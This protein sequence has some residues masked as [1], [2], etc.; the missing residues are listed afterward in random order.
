M[1]L[2]EEA[3]LTKQFG[4][5]VCLRAD[6]WGVGLSMALLMGCTSAE[7]PA[8]VEATVTV[9][10]QGG[11]LHATNG[12]YFDPDGRL[13]VG[14]AS[15]GVVAAIDPETGEVLERWGPEE[16]VRGP[17]DLTVGPDG[18]VFWTDFG[19]GEVRRR[20][21]DGTTTLI[22]SPGLGVNPITFSDDGRLFVSQCALGVQLF[23]IDPDGIEEPRLINDQLG[24][25]CGLNGMDWGPDDRLYGPR[26][27]TSEVV[28]VDVDRGTVETVASDF[29]APV[30]LKFDSQYRLHVLDTGAGEVLRVDVETG[31]TEVVGH[32]GIGSDNLAFSADDRLFVSSFTDSYIVEVI[33]P[34]TNR[35]VIAGGVSFPGGI[36]YVPTTG[37]SGRL[38]LADRRA[39]RELDPTTGTQVHAVN[40]LVSDVGEA[41]SVHP[42]GA[43]LILS[44]PTSVR[45]WDPDGDRLVARFDGFEEAVDA[46]PL[47]SDIIV[48]EYETGSVVRFDPESPDARTVVASGLE[49]PAGLATHGGSVYVA[50]RSGTIFQILEDGEPL[51]PPRAVATGLAGPEGIA[52]DENGT[53]YVVEEDAG[54]VTQVDP[55]TG[56]T[57][58]V[59]DG[60]ILSG[61]EQKSIGETTAVGFLT[62]IAVGDGSLY[63]S[64]YPENRV[65]RIDR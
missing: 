16:G 51:D 31:D 57:T 18:S 13:Y 11:P 27:S 37:G 49:A 26:M 38:F 65:Y 64:S 54:R 41:M 36:A 3:P 55:A 29:E 61:L 34:D 45:I 15:S 50:D 12:M 47:D 35:D 44:G 43:H 42:H 39:L 48:S 23:E 14:S 40:G 20:T 30:A 60:L 25:G 33:G 59:A 4:Q 1:F 5:P 19:F 24:P 2:F 58:L 56:T 6:A 7:P 10:A 46:L 9:L 8:P 62:G 52:V 17:D 63:V 28:R 21:P 32:V 53:L 22:A